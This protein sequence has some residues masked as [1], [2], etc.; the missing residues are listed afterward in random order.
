MV[1]D[2]GT[3]SRAGER[4]RAHSGHCWKCAA[5]RELSWRGKGLGGGKG[6]IRG[7]ARIGNRGRCEGM[8]EKGLR[9]GKTKGKPSQVKY[10]KKQAK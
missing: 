5:V 1:K 8:A 10:Q 4:H 7:S 2:L 6:E 9:T 3:L